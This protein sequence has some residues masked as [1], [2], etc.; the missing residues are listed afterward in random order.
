MASHKQSFQFIPKNCIRKKKKCH[1][2]HD[3]ISFSFPSPGHENLSRQ[4]SKEDL[5]WFCWPWKVFFSVE[6]K[7]LT[8]LNIKTF[9]F[10]HSLAPRHTWP[11]FDCQLLQGERRRFYFELHKEKRGPAT[12]LHAYIC[13]YSFPSLIALQMFHATGKLHCVSDWRRANC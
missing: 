10:L 5:S 3:R 8:A 6:T 2:N 1:K 9:A 4:L 13:S 11:H 12:Y 7:I